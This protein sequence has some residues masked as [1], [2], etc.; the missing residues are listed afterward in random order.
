[1]M[2]KH[3]AKNEMKNSFI[4]LPFVGYEPTSVYI[5]FVFIRYPYQIV[6]ITRQDLEGE[7]LE[8]CC[9]QQLI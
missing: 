4:Y 5:F 9:I 8:T 7:G 2:L 1:M 3:E 6:Q